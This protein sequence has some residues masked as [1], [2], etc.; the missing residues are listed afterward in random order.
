MD[1]AALPNRQPLD[2]QVAMDER[3]FLFPDGKA[4][5]HLLLSS[6]GQGRVCIDAVFGFNETRLAPRILTL[7]LDD[8]RELGRKLVEAVYHAR[9]H[10]VISD[11]AR[12]TINVV[13]NG[14][15][16]QIGE[17]S[18]STDLFLSTGVIW[19]VCNGLLRLVDSM[20][21]VVAH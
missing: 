6:E 8:A 20:S 12:I 21:P 3:A 13:T 9:T 15:F 10:Y 2:V 18:N 4:V 11:T 16:V 7:T 5:T 14:Y 17:V 1:T 19:R